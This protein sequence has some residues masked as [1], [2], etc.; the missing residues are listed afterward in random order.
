MGV[1][2]AARAAGGDVQQGGQGGYVVHG[3]LA[4]GARRAERY[5]GSGI[6]CSGVTHGGEERK[7]E[8]NRY[9]V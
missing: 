7:V 2:G 8:T 9:L 1:Q 5:A 3:W 6:A 4:S